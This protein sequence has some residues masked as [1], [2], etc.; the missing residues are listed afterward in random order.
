[1]R[2]GKI[3]RRNHV[4]LLVL[5]KKYTF[6]KRKGYQMKQDQVTTQNTWADNSY[7][8]QSGNAVLFYTNK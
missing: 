3:L 8:V 4:V 5:I 1:M 2:Y 7:F 6:G